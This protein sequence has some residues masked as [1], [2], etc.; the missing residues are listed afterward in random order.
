MSRIFN[1][2]LKIYLLR[3]QEV[4]DNRTLKAKGKYVPRTQIC[5]SIEMFVPVLLF[6]VMVGHFRVL[7][8]LTLKTRPSAKPF[9]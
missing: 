6:N 3:L 4:S 8:T 5:V 7:K 2:Y 1:R 9:L